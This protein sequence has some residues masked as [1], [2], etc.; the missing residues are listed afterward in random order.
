MDLTPEAPS[1]Q[2]PASEYGIQRLWYQPSPPQLLLTVKP[3]AAVILVVQRRRP[4]APFSNEYQP[5]RNENAIVAK[6]ITARRHQ[7]D[8]SST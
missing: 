4:H 8:L 5:A 7:K 6:H 2:I 3:E 1:P